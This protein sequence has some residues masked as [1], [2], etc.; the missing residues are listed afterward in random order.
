MT[1][2]TPDCGWMVIL[3]Y[4]PRADSDAR[5]YARLLAEVDNP[6][7][8]AVD[9]IAQYA[10][11]A[12]A[13]TLAGTPG[14]THFDFMRFRSAA[15][16]DRAWSNPDLLAFAA[17]WVTQWGA[18]PEAADASVNYHAHVARRVAG[19]PGDDAAPLFL[20]LDPVAAEAGD[21]LWEIV[22]PIVGTPAFRHFAIRRGPAPAAGFAPVLLEGRL[23]A[24]P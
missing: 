2:A 21:E 17:G 14:F 15:D 7:F 13:R 22:R 9:G 10:N 23:L 3:P 12:V 5:G 8:N 24:A 1:R 18:A 4:T 20:A 19:T 16:I 11:W 6:F